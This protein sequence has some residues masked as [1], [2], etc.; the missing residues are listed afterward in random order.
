MTQKSLF[1]KQK[2]EPEHKEILCATN[3]DSSADETE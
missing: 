3:S 1:C 2:E